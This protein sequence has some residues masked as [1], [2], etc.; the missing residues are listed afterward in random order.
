LKRGPDDLAAMLPRASGKKQVVKKPVDIDRY[1][2]SL[3][4]IRTLMKLKKTTK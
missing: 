3:N 1:T 4:G 2:K